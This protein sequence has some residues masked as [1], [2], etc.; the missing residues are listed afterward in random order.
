MWTFHCAQKTAQ[1]ID[2]RLQIFWRALIK[3]SLQMK[4]VM[5]NTTKLHNKKSQP[6]ETAVK[7]LEED[8]TGRKEGCS[9]VKDR[10]N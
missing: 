4:V 3:G 5:I 9:S 8:T 1:Q 7:D 10:P 2:Y 6:A